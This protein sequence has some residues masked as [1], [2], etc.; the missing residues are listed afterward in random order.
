MRKREYQE[1]FRIK[2]H[3]HGCIHLICLICNN[4][5]QSTGNYFDLYNIVTKAKKHMKGH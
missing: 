2:H 4:F 1:Y 3:E 5:I